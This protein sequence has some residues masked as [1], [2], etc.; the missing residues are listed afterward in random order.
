MS[1]ADEIKK[2]L[3]LKRSMKAAMPVAKPASML[4]TKRE[5]KPKENEVPTVD[6]TAFGMEEDEEEAFRE[7]VAEHIRLGEIK[8]AAKKAQENLV[9]R[10][11]AM[12]EKYKIA[13]TVCD[14]APIS[15]YKTT[16]RSVN[17]ILL[18]SHG[19]S[20]ATIKACTDESTSNTLKIGKGADYEG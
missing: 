4:P 5:K 7:L 11:K 3:A 6:I 13:K 12:C 9:P 14:G 10:L 20:A 15:Y 2:E 16:R 1:R 18:L 8:T 17:S 19:V